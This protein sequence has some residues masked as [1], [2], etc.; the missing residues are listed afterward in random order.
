MPRG[1]G[2]ERERG[3]ALRMQPLP[4]GLRFASA[5]DAYEMASRE[6]ARRPVTAGSK[7]PRPGNRTRGQANGVHAITIEL[8]LERE[9]RL[10]RWRFRAALDACELDN[11]GGWL[12]TRALV[13]E[14]HD[15]REPGD[16]RFWG[17]LGA[18]ESH[19]IPRIM[20][21]VRVSSGA[22]DPRGFRRTDR[23][24]RAADSHTL[25]RNNI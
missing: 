24:C 15:V 5:R 23:W 3:Q 6:Q 17:W 10:G 4:G 25:L 18:C 13:H 12:G 14:P 20:D 1:W 11:G 16:G 2:M 9:R 7:W 8:A 22:Y 19:Q 21:V